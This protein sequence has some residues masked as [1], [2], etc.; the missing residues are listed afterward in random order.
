MSLDQGTRESFKTQTIL[1]S[2]VLSNQFQRCS[3][4][5]E[6]RRIPAMSHVKDHTTE[7]KRHRVSVASSRVHPCQQNTMISSLFWM[8]GDI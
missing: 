2:E 1:E 8:F 4:S 3:F 6:A 7:A 5:S